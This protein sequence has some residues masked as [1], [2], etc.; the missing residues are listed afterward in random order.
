[1]DNIPVILMLSVQT[2]MEILRVFVMMAS[3]EMV[4]AAQVLLKLRFN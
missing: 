1:M 3:V 4:T 2:Q